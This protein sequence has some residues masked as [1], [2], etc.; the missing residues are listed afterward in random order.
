MEANQ[1][2][3]LHVPARRAH[4]VGADVVAEARR[5]RAEEEIPRLPGQHA[6][7]RVSVKAWRLL[8]LSSHEVGK[9]SLSSDEE[10]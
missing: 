10:T 2:A 6:L 8:S 7:S 4:A 5:G 3:A 1:R 9:R